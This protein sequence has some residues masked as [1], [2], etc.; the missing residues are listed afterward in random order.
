M[1]DWRGEG[2]GPISREKTLGSGAR[3]Q[4]R[5][6]WGQS[7]FCHR[8]AGQ[9]W[10][11]PGRCPPRFPRLSNGSNAGSR[12]AGGSGSVRGSVCHGRS[13]SGISSRPYFE[14]A[15]SP[16]PCLR[17]MGGQSW[18]P[19]RA[20]GPSQNWVPASAQPQMAGLGRAGR[21]PQPEAPAPQPGTPPWSS[22]SGLE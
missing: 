10:T 15:R 2:W 18:R 21:S 20:A 7:Q 17:P 9:I 5:K 8:P 16:H 6:A 22:A 12:W 14:L 13:L 3:P 11:S 19:G 4:G 1:K